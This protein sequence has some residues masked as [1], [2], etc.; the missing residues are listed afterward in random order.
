MKPVVPWSRPPLQPS[1]YVDLIGARYLR[2]GRGPDAFD[3][4]GLV[5][6]LQRRQGVPME[7]PAT[8]DGERAAASVMLAILRRRWRELEHPRAGCIVFF[9]NQMHVATMIDERRFL[10]TDSY[11]EGACV[12]KLTDA[13]WRKAACSFHRPFD[14]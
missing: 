14:E 6:E 10:H 7:I 1:M 2:N 5:V 12:E 13:L 8:P 11:T 3:C 4:A 9:R